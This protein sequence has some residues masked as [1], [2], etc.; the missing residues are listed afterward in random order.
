ME[1]YLTEWVTFVLVFLRVASLMVTAPIVGHQAV[2]VAV[3]L[4]VS[5][6]VAYVMLPIVAAQSSGIDTR[7]AAVVVL[8]LKEVLVGA[9]LGFATG[10]LFSGVQY[11]GEFMAYSMG[12]SMASVFDPESAQNVPIIGE[13]LY[14][15]GLLVF[16]ALNGH[17]FILES[18]AVT[19]Q[20][21]PLGGLTIAGPFTERMVSLTGMVF[22][23]AV[24][25][26][27][28]VIV[29]T[30]LTSVGFAIMARVMPQA[31]ILVISFP[32]TI[33]VGLLVTLSSA[34][35]LVFVFKKLLS[36]FEQNILDLIRVM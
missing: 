10:L 26:A 8:A 5:L 7:L 21:V 24:K 1:L 3:K 30:F 18:L 13:L 35:L 20:S 16:L 6:F 11:A 36:M 34:P 2:P 23:V 32:V 9:I 31:N 19:F 12:L 29:A 27:A 4:A 17:H 28:P 33:G 25:M 14:L 22:V 15:F